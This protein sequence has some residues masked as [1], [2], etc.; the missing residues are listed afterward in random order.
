M[1]QIVPLCADFEEKLIKLVWRFKANTASA[2]VI[3]SST[4][5]VT[6]PPSATASITGLNEKAVDAAAELALERKEAP[7]KAKAKKSRGCWGWK[8][9]SSAANSRDPEK[10][11]PATR[12]ARMLA[13]VY[14]GLGAALSICKCCIQVFR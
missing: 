5:V 12:P 4:G 1:D 9:S 11:A 14:V 7:A 13:P 8:L 6:T 10:A 3:T 2:S